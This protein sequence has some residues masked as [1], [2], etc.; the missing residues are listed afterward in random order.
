MKLFWIKNVKITKWSHS[1]K[2]Y[3]SI[4]VFN[5]ELQFKD[6]ES[7]IKTKLITLLYESKNFKFVAIKDKKWWQNTIWHFFSNSKVETII[8][9]SDIDGLLQSIYST[10]SNIQKCLGRSSGWIIDSVIDHNSNSFD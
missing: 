7:E 10:I 3:V 5:P 2:G 6:T 9:E 1:Y 4:Q 8:N